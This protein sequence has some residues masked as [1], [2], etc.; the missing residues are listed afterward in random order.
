[1]QIS[2]SKYDKNIVCFEYLCDKYF[3]EALR[4]VQNNL[5]LFL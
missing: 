3:S 4:I 5:H 2:Q 1:M